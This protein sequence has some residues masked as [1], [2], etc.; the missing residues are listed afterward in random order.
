MQSWW[1]SGIEH[2]G[3]LDPQERNT[4]PTDS[5]PFVDHPRQYLG[6]ERTLERH[7][8]FHTTL[9]NQHA[10]RKIEMLSQCPKFL[11]KRF[12]VRLLTS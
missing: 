1:N 8:N 12:E 2:Y 3:T 9:T 7:G 5:T 10:V 4:P 6:F 11:T